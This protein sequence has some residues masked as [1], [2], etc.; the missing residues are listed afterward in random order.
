MRDTREYILNDSSE[1][2]V[3]VEQA[4]KYQ[5]EI[6]H[7]E[8]SQDF[9][10]WPVSQDSYRAVLSFPFPKNTTIPEGC[11]SL[12]WLESIIWDALREGASAEKNRFVEVPKNMDW[13]SPH[14][15][16]WTIYWLFVRVN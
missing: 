15:S 13:E 12:V 16:R 14:A 5:A 2:S 8:L 10:Y 9:G 1:F 6:G 7:S 11:Q 3:I 4:W